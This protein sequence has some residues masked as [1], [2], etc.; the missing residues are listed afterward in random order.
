MKIKTCSP[1]AIRP[2]GTFAKDILSRLLIDLA[3]ASSR[4]EGNTYTRLDTQNLLEFGQRAEGKDAAEAQMIIN[5]KTAIEYVVGEAEETRIRTT[6]ILS[7]HAALSDNLLADPTEEGRLRERPV[8]ISGS[9]YTPTAIPQ[10]IR[11]AFERIVESLNAI[12]DPFEAA[13]FAMVQ[14]AYLQPFVDVNKRTSR[15]VANLPLIAANLSPL[16]FVG[17]NEREYVLGTLAVYEVRRTELLR[18]FFIT[19]YERSAAQYRVFRDSVVQPDPTRLRY[20]NE[21]RAVVRELVVGGSAPSV[22]NIRRLAAEAGIPPADVQRFSE[23][24]LELL[25]SLNDGSAARYALRPSEF[26][27]WRQHVRNMST[28]EGSDTNEA[29]S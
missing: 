18:D 16:S 9:T 20:R 27:E 3:W 4:L 25:L 21:L 14:I 1:T 5:H 7:T 23:V 22:Q 17:A 26:A 15:L 24:T 29:A 6:T 13:F 19:A 12:P 2:A 28:S 8:S 11:E 10:V